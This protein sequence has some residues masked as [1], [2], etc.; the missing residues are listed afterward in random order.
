MQV[1][2]PAPSLWARLALR[3]H[4]SPEGRVAAP[5]PWSRAL[6]RWQWVL[7]GCAMPGRVHSMREGGHRWMALGA[8]CAGT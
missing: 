3:A 1:Q 7:P 8:L 4:S 2:I 6:G 5:A